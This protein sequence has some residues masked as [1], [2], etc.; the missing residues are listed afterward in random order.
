MGVREGKFYSYLNYGVEGYNPKVTS[1]Y[2]SNGDLIRVDEEWRGKTYSQTISGT[3]IAS[4]V[5]DT[6]VV[7]DPWIEI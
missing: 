7:Y 4:Q 6:V 5:V 3:G 1:Y 2:N